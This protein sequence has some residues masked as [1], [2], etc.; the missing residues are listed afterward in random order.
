M[1]VGASSNPAMSDVGEQITS[2]VPLGPRRLPAPPGAG[3][4]GADGA[5]FE[6][7]W[8]CGVRLPTSQMIAD[9]GHACAD[10]RWYCGDTRACTERWTARGP[11]AIGR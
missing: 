3:R 11:R 9:G 2:R 5:A 4:H 7:C 8:M 6:S 1:T 10:L